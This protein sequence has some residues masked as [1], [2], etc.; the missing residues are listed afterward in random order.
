M[1][2]DEMTEEHMARTEED[3]QR[4]TR[5]EIHDSKVDEMRAMTVAMQ[6]LVLAMMENH[7]Q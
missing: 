4:A 3:Y 7:D 6:G 1:F 5:Q 2:E